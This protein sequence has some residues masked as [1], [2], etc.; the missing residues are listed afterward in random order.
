MDLKDIRHFVFFNSPCPEI[1]ELLMD[2]AKFVAFTGAPASIVRRAGGEFSLFGG[3]VSGTTIEIKTDSLIIQDWMGEDW[4]AGHHSRLTFA[5]TPVHEGRGCALKLHQ[6][7]VPAD[8]L[9]HI[10]EGWQS[11]YW[12]PMAEYPRNVKVAVVRRFLEEFKN[13]ANIDIVD[14]TWTADSV[15]HVPG[16]Q[17]PP[18]RAGQKSVGKAIFGAFSNI[19]VEVN[20]TIVEGDRVVERHTATA[21]HKGDFMGIPASGKKVHWTENHIYRIKDGKIA[22]A[23]SEVSFHDLVAQISGSKSPAA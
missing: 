23:W 7:G 13:H 8:K 21:V 18:G 2:E 4:P 11:Y 3:K 9:D 12:G 1:F 16:M 5:L 20:D 17:V 22:E 15:L 6:T 19:H 10:N 14:E